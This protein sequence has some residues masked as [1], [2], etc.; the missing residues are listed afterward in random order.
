MIM[1]GRH[2]QEYCIVCRNMT[3]KSHAVGETEMKINGE[4]MNKSECGMYCQRVRTPSSEA[5]TGPRLY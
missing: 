1:F 3:M 2:L 5:R 4:R